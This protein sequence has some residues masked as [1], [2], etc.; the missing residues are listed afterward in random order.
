[1][2]KNRIELKGKS[3]QVILDKT[4]GTIW[5]IQQRQGKFD[6]NFVAN[7]ENVEKISATPN[8]TGDIIAT[9]WKLPRDEQDTTKLED[10]AAFQS[11]GNWQPEWTSFSKDIR[12]VNYKDGKVNVTY[13]GKSKQ[14]G[15][16]KSFGLKMTYTLEKKD[17]LLWEIE[18][19][20]TTKSL[21][22]IG[23]LGLPLAANNDYRGVY[24]GKS[25]LEQTR[26]GKYGLMQKLIHEEKVLCHHFAAGH[27]SY[28]LLQRP[29]GN[30]PFLLVHFAGD[31]AIECVY[32]A[33]GCDILALYSWATK[34]LKGWHNDWVNG[35]TSL[36]LK[37]AETRKFQVRF[38]F[39][40]GYSDIRKKVYDSNNLGIRIIPSMVVQ[41]DTPVYVEIQS[42][43][44][45]DKVEF[46]AD[47]ITIIKKEQSND[48]KLLTLQ[49]KKRGQKTIRLR[50]DK[51]KWTNLHFY[52]VENLEQLI[53]ARSKFITERQFYDN[54]LDPYN[55]HHM[56]LP[57]DYNTQSP[58]YDSDEVWEVGGSDEFGFSEPLYL[59]EK[60]LYY[61]S[62]KEV[63]TLETYVDDCLFKHI[64]NP[65]T[66]EVRASLFWKNRYPSSPWGHWP[67]ERS[68]QLWRT[69]NYPHPAN[70][71]HDLYQ[72]GTKYG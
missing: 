46:L 18:I 9:V 6:T 69:Y 27:S 33:E 66:Y 15:G 35:H 61:P 47:N 60:N 53:K 22:E 17:S 55:R 52:C 26:S 57:F 49:F 8:W 4:K 58:M 7:E 40:K 59:A 3:M 63:E 42:K 21:L 48:I 68:G 1:M 43:K 5:S 37:P 20:N 24:K 70:I 44:A 10:V 38:S 64:Q 28:S 19:T 62:K 39:V 11:K 36:L 32:H 51:N 2:P 41:E 30:A 72:I 16:I 67:E 45:I 65:E 71:Y 13:S 50:Y 23:E 12:K 34:K 54:P 31:T 14:Q 29:L 56:F 25:P